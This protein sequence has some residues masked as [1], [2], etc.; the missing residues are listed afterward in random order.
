MISKLLN[1]TLRACLLK[2][3]TECNDT[4]NV[5]AFSKTDSDGG[6]K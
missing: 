5:M 2:V 3:I 1:K 6:N 4:F